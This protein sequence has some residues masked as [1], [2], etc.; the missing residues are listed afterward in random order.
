MPWVGPTAIYGLLRRPAE[1]DT[2]GTG[3]WAELQG[4]E[5][6]RQPL[7][8]L[9]LTDPHLSVRGSPRSPRFSTRRSSR[10]HDLGSQLGTWGAETASE[11]IADGQDHEEPET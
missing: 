7:A 11:R 4:G 8:H 9:P 10:F 3:Q 6:A 5:G 2:R 1:N